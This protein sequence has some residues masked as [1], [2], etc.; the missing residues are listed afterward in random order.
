MPDEFWRWHFVKEFGWSLEQVDN[1]SLGDLR[2][3]RSIQDGLA[4]VKGSIYK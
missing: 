1:L 2:E 4:K 3:Y